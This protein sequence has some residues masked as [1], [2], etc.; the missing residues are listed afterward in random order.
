[1]EQMATVRTRLTPPILDDLRGRLATEHIYFPRLRA[2]A[3]SKYQSND[4]MLPYLF[5]YYGFMEVL[6]EDISR[7]MEELQDSWD[8]T[9]TK[10]KLAYSTKVERRDRLS[11]EIAMYDAQT[12]LTPIRRPR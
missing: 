3:D 6:N 4:P 1:M 2:E 12:T 7:F 10:G 5:R 11:Q 9:S 8:A